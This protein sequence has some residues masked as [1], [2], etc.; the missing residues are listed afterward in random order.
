[1]K[2]WSEPRQRPQKLSFGL[3]SDLVRNPFFEAGRSDEV[4]EHLLQAARGGSNADENFFTGREAALARIVGWMRQRRPGLFVITGPPGSG[5]SAILGRIL[6]LS[7]ETERKRVLQNGRVPPNL[8]PGQGSVDAHLQARKTTVEAATQDLLKRLGL[9]PK[10][11]EN[12]LL[13]EA[14]RRCHEGNPL[15]LAIDGLDEAGSASR[16]LATRILKPLAQYALLIVAT[17]EVPSFEQESLITLLG[18]PADKLDLA[19]EDEGTRRDIHAYVLRRLQGISAGMDASLVAN[20]ITTVGEAAESFLFARLVTSQ[21]R[22]KPVDT[23]R[24][25]WDLSLAPSVESALERDLQGVEIEIG[26]QPHRTAA[27]ELLFALTLAY[28]SGFPPDD[29]WPAV[30]TATSE[31][32]IK[33]GRA[34]IYETVAQ[35]ARHVITGMCGDQPVYRIAHQK[36]IEYLSASGSS[37]GSWATVLSRKVA[38]ADAI[39]DLYTRYLDTGLPPDKPAYL[40][41]YAWRHL[42]EAGEHGLN[43]LE[44]LVER[45]RAAFLPDLAL[46]FELAADEVWA[47]GYADEARVLLEK[48]VEA[49]RELEDP[50]RLCVALFQLAMIRL[51]KGDQESADQAAAE[52]AK[53]AQQLPNT[54]QSRTLIGTSL[55]GRS[56]TLLSEGR[57]EAAKLL[58]EEALQLASRDELDQDLSDWQRR[59]TAGL[60]AGKAAASLGDFVSAERLLRATVDLVDQNG[61]PD[62]DVSLIDA[63]ST[64]AFV[65][66]MRAVKGELDSA[67]Q[68]LPASST[69]GERLMESQIKGSIGVIPRT[70]DIARGLLFVVRSRL[71]DAEREIDV[72]HLKLPSVE[73]LPNLLDQ[74]IDTVAPYASQLRDAAWVLANALQFRSLWRTGSGAAEDRS[75]AIKAIRPFADS[76]PLMA[77]TMGAVLDSFTTEDLQLLSQQLLPANGLV[78]SQEEAVYFLRKGGTPFQEVLKQA[79]VRLAYISQLA[80]RTDLQKAALAEAIE[81]CRNSPLQDPESKAV[82]AALMT[83]LAALNSEDGAIFF[84]LAIEAL[85]LARSLQPT[86]ELSAVLAVCELNAGVAMMFT[87]NSVEAS[88]L[89]KSVI[90]RLESEEDNPISIPT[91]ATACTNLAQLEVDAGNFLTA[92]DLAERALTLFEAPTIMSRMVAD[93]VPLARLAL[94][95]ALR[96]MPGRAEEGNAIIDGVIGP[97][98]E[99]LPGSEETEARLVLLLN[100]AG[101]AIWDRTLALLSDR[102]E[103]SRAI[104]MK[105]I[106]PRGEIKLGVESILAAMAEAQTSEV[107]QVRA[108]ARLQRAVDP[109][110]FDE[111]WREAQGSIPAWLKIDPLFVAEVIFWLRTD[112][113]ESSRDYLDAHPALLAPETD[114]VLKDFRLA[115]GDDRSLNQHL[116]I[117]AT[118]RNSN[119][120]AAYAPILARVSIHNWLASQDR[121]E[122]FEEHPELLSPAVTGLLIERSADGDKDSGILAAIAELARRKEL[123]LASKLIGDPASGLSLLEAAWASKDATR[124]AALAGIVRGVSE[125][126]SLVRK[127]TTALAIA[128]VLENRNETATALAMEAAQ[129]ATPE[130]RQ[131][132]IEILSDAIKHHPKFAGALANLIQLIAPKDE[133]SAA[134]A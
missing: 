56:L 73:A 89:F 76:S 111:A 98:V 93:N 54:S 129:D 37:A 67:G 109:G 20:A 107:F 5:K 1:L 80:G 61:E 34:N 48:A 115:G 69:V 55:L 84:H 27:R 112:A 25:G 101:S 74:V 78:G 117:L 44:K 32:G 116:E 62:S 99:D 119:V 133:E 28:G 17:R 97:L 82:Q 96:G 35:L 71:L 41:R 46:G 105:R 108:N 50:Q 16:D 118:A 94:G 81:I 38:T 39:F 64:L 31:T 121:I 92:L 18:T 36:L 100:R 104:R 19:E 40:W 72:S 77:G 87:G 45:D 23:S 122:H 42:A 59:S 8:D 30:A 86:E 26:G 53:I 51:T 68:L 75:A 21:L 85:A 60:V 90:K 70:V 22:E 120:A 15:V 114:L 43:L 106:R 49:R 95:L 65:H 7:S 131:D 83:D 66:F 3:V 6:S 58:A 10:N 113:W 47:A 91:I 79:L 29:V 13:F 134:G 110:L 2:D 88:D 57:Y 125:D 126:Q 9:D 127:S 124:L 123:S 24:A 11:W 103:F 63:L 128:R 14:E 12:G 4:V 33:Y 132:L 130:Q 102:P 52:A